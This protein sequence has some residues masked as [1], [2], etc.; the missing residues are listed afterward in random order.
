MLGEDVLFQ[1][2]G[3]L[4]PQIRQRRISPTEL[5]ESYLQRIRRYSGALNAFETVTADLARRQARQAEAE[6]NAGRYRGPLHGIPWGAKD[7]LDTAGIRTTWGAVPCR[8]RTP[9]AD[10]TVVK[11]LN[12]AGA[13]MLGKLAMVEFAGGLGYRWADASITGPGRNPWE[14]SRW[15]GGSSSG[16]GAAVGGGLVTFAIGT[17]TWGSILCPSAFCGVTGLRPTY[18]RV[19]RAGAMVCSY[20]FDKI[21]PLARSAADCRAVLAAIAGPDP[22]DSSAS[23]EPLRIDRGRR[24]IG[25]LHA[26]VIPLDFAK[27]GEPEVKKGFEEALGVLGRLGLKL[28]TTTLPDFPAADVAGAII[29]AEALSA[30]ETFYRDG[31]VKQLKDPYAPYQMEL[32]SPM[33]AAD[34]VK[35]WRM[36]EVLQEKMSDFFG[37]YDVIVTPNF[38]S[39]APPISK[40]LN[41]SLNYSDPVGGVGNACGLPSIAL[42]MGKGRGGLP[43][44]FQIMGAPWDEGLLLDLGEAYQGKTVFHRD[45]PNLAQTT[46]R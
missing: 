45:H 10:A 8:D 40:D 1:S 29:T 13:V 9:E 36:R 46:S 32:A 2:I 12:D 5:T 4:A 35:A 43:I 44:G 42:P 38:M 23:D 7:L 16:A 19:S 21:G 41:E 39:V 15:T 17:E 28:E 24:S 37:R 27:H 33:T 30:F 18:G 20:T 14:P 26:A 22:A 11:R 31:R 25:G 3:E 6:I 34:L